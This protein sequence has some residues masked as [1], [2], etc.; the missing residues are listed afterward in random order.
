MSPVL[1]INPRTKTKQEREKERKTAERVKE[2][3]RRKGKSGGR[4]TAPRLTRSATS[5][6]QPSSSHSHP[7]LLLPRSIH[8]LP[9]GSLRWGRGTQGEREGGVVAIYPVI[10]TTFRTKDGRRILTPPR[11][12]A[13]P[14]LPSLS[15]Y[16]VHRIQFIGA[17]SVCHNINS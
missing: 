6:P 14:S 4:L 10:V 2:E 16:P 8:S 5:A 7:P 15:Q 11:F 13:S 12:F 3:S 9:L 1:E 17:F